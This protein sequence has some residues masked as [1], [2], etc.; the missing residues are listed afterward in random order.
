MA[1]AIPRPARKALRLTG[2]PENSRTLEDARH[3]RGVY[4]ELTKG[5]RWISDGE[6]R[7]HRRSRQRQIERLEQRFAFWDRRCSELLAAS[8]A[9]TPI[10]VNFS[11]DRSS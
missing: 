11:G 6:S 7:T 5:F 8:Q 10:E 4:E 2:E 3:W 9:A 1:G